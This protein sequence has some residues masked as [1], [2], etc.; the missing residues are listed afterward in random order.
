MATNLVLGGHSFIQQLGTDAA[1][2]ADQAV[3]IVAACLDNGIVSFDTTYAPERVALGRA[4][5]TLGRRDE[6]TILAWNFFEHFGPDEQVGASTAYRPHHLQLM[7][8]ELQTDRI[9]LLIVHP[10]EDPA[11]QAQQQ[12]VAL[13]WLRQGYVRQLGVFMPDLDAA[14]APYSVAVAPY[15]VSTPDAAT[16][17]AAYADRGWQTYAV[18]P[19][20]RG[21]ELERIVGESSRATAEIADL[22]LR[23]AA[24]G[25]N[26]DFLIVAMRKVEW[27]TANID[28]WRRGPLDES[29]AP[30]LAR[31]TRT[32]L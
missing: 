1:P 11:E 8:D 25:P 6:A 3:E 13:E 7:L 16:A 20:V 29:E 18:S 28:S 10:V 4:L 15:N 32:R 24:F 21:W 5:A 27:V 2:D 31:A 9:D 12:E 26:V 22:M 17:F 23:Y 30:I 19:F 14:A